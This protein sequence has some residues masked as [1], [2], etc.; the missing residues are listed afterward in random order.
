MFVWIICRHRCLE[1]LHSCMC[2]RDTTNRADGGLLFH[3]M[4]WFDAPKK[5]QCQDDLW[6]NFVISMILLNHS[7]LRGSVWE[8]QENTL[9]TDHLSRSLNLTKSCYVVLLSFILR[10]FSFF[11]EMGIRNIEQSVTET[12]L[13]NA[14]GIYADKLCQHINI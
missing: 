5:L 4:K 13:E 10:S 3:T 12:C 14:K 11:L 1:E 7:Y 6:F 8:R 2:S 9:Q